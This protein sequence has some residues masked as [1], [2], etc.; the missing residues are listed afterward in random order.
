MA[1]RCHHRSQIQSRCP[2]WEASPEKEWA[3][4]CVAAE[5]AEAVDKVAAD[6]AAAAEAAGGVAE[7]GGS[8]PGPDHRGYDPRERGSCL[9]PNRPG[10]DGAG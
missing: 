1:F 6:C 5:V 10:S 8:D 3:A 2:S 4:G 7:E 9:G